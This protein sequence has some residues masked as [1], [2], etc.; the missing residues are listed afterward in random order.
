VNWFPAAVD[1]PMPSA[2][3]FEVAVETT[4]PDAVMCWP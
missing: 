2:T 3:Q 1:I 4:W